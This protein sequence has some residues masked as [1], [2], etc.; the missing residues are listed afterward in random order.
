MPRAPVASVEK[1]AW[2]ASRCCHIG[3]YSRSPLDPHTL[4]TIPEALRIAQETFASTGGL[5]AAGLMRPDGSFE[6]VREDIG[7]HNAVDKVLGFRLLQDQVPV[8]DRALVVSG[9]VG[10]EIVQKARMGGI[11]AIIAFGA[12]SSLS[13]ELARASGMGLVGFLRADRW[14]QYT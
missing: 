11:G 12:A 6:V 8:A 7:R 2:I 1:R 10:F 4:A 9:R 14:T 5:H 13:V 3:P